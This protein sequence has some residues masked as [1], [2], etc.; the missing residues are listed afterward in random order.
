MNVAPITLRHGET[1][2][3]MTV[4]RKMDAAAF[5]GRYQLGCECGNT[6]VYFTAKALMSG[7]AK[8]CKRCADGNHNAQGENK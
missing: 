8:E 4:L 2:G 7:R 6:H 5:R 1:F 3:R